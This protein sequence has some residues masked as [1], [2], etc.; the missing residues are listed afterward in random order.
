MI[1]IKEISWKKKVKEKFQAPFP[2][3]PSPYFPARVQGLI[4]N[5]DVC[6]GKTSRNRMFN[7]FFSSPSS[8]FY[9]PPTHL[10][11][12]SSKILEAGIF[13][14]PSRPRGMA[15]ECIH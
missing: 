14:A 13:S 12:P 4:K 3:D 6:V 9:A 15:P 5:T 1:W 7:H 2:Q 10:E 8:L 11:D